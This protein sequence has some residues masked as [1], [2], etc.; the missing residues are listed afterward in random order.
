[1]FGLSPMVMTAV[2][3]VNVP[4][5]LYLGRFF[6]GDWESFLR[7]VRFWFTPDALSFFRGEWDEDRWSE[8]KLGLFFL[9]CGLLVTCELGALAKMLGTGR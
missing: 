3:I 7:C 8:M 6:F 9:L 5:Y 4:L 2:V 1:M